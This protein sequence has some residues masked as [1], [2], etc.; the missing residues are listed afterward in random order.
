[1][2]SKR[3]TFDVLFYVKRQATMKDGSLPVMCKIT[4]NGTRSCFS[5]KMSVMPEI[6]DGG[7]AVGRSD[8]AKKIN[9]DLGRIEESVRSHHRRLEDRDAHVTAEKVKN[10]HL[11]LSAHHE[12]L[13]KVYDRFRPRKNQ[14]NSLTPKI[15]EIICQVALFGIKNK[16]SLLFRLRSLLVN[17]ESI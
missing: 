1:M 14:A 12:T 13:L 15:D 8:E 17:N 5:C 11:G 4:V 6:W 3:S 2:S 9:R 16:K 10:A 7:K